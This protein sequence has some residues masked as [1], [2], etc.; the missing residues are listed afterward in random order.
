MNNS[1]QNEHLH[2]FT[3]SFQLNYTILKC[4]QYFTLCVDLRQDDTS[5]YS[6]G[7]VNIR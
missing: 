4:I 6:K 3:N 1:T 7:M 5:V 2:I